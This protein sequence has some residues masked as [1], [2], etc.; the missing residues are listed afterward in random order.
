MTFEMLLEEYF[1]WLIAAGVG[2]L[3]LII[4]GKI[5]VICYCSRCWKNQEPS[6]SWYRLNH[7]N[8]AL[9]HQVYPVVRGHGTHRFHWKSP[10]HFCKVVI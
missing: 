6:E 8:P 4:A 5:S 3:L 9:R 10:L 7:F 1:P 2:L